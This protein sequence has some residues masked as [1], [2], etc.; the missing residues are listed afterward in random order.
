MR[1]DFGKNKNDLIKQWE[2]SNDCQWPTYDKDVY[3]QG[4]KLIRRAGDKYDAHHIQ[5]LTFGGENTSNN[6][7]P[8]HALEHYD[9]QGIH[10]SDSAF[11]RIEKFYKEN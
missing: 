2:N 8:L 6:L 7:T 4:G 9:K 11:G 1:E 5:P 3:S 10:S